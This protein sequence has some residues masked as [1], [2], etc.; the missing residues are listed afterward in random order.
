[1]LDGRRWRSR[2]ASFCAVSPRTAIVGGRGTVR[3]EQERFFVH[4]A[5]SR[6]RGYRVVAP[7]CGTAVRH[8]VVA[9]LRGLPNNSPPGQIRST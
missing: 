6:L 4:R 5:A 9:S 2:S 3:A 7:S 1:M 8:R